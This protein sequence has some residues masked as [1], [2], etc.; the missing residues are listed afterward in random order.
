MESNEAELVLVPT[1]GTQPLWLTR[2]E[3]SARTSVGLVRPG[4]GR[5]AARFV[6]IGQTRGQCNPEA[7]GYQVSVAL[8]VQS[9]VYDE[10]PVDI[11]HS[12]RGCAE[13]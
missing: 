4:S 5:N 8:R 3:E 1:D 6:R 11:G 13:R 7:A 2:N 12:A 10:G 9:T